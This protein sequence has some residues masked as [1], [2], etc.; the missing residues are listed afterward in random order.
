MG[1]GERRESNGS[2]PKEERVRVSMRIFP[3]FWMSLW[4][5]CSRVQIERQRAVF[6][7]LDVGEGKGIQ[8]YRTGRVLV[9]LTRSFDRIV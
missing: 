2:Q 1:G 6:R 3:V 5:D 9:K 8:R 7:A 4:R